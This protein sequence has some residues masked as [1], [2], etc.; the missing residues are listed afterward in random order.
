MLQWELLHN[1]I[2]K[3]TESNIES[4][5]SVLSLKN[6]MTGLSL[7]NMITRLSFVTLK[8]TIEEALNFWSWL[9]PG[10]VATPGI[11]RDVDVIASSIEAGNIITVHTI[12][13]EIE[14]PWVQSASREKVSRGIQS[15]DAA[16]RACGNT[17]RS[18][19]RKNR[20]GGSMSF[21]SK[22]FAP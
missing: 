12:H 7:A 19:C 5:S 16:R 3:K 13:G 9:N 20:Q 15:S 4:D 8:G 14:V 22:L 1:D 18:N 10:V 17:T 2:V 11:A 21:R 6:G